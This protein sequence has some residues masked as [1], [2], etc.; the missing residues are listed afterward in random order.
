MAR[1]ITPPGRAGGPGRGELTPPKSADLNSL[2][3]TGVG[4][5]WDIALVRG[6]F[7]AVSVAA[8]SHF[9]PFGLSSRTAALLGLPFHVAAL[10][11]ELRL[12]RARP[13]RLTG[14]RIRPS[15]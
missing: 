14:A 1:T 13:H 3:D 5:W 4:S 10:L 11:R 2:T 12:R 8:C 9:R 15:R 6:I 7:A